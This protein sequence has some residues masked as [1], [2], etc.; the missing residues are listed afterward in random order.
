[1][2]DGNFNDKDAKQPVS[3][4]STESRSASLDATQILLSE[5]YFPEKHIL[6]FTDA[7]SIFKPEGELFIYAV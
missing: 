6:I 3:L 7:Y 2:A 1:M 5:N 4:E